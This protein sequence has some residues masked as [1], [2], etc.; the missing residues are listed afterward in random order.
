MKTFTQNPGGGF[1]AY[2]S[3]EL[4]SIEVRIEQG[5]AASGPQADFTG[6]AVNYG[7]TIDDDPN[8]D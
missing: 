6:G 7:G 1:S 8:K 2:Q 4:H 3:P 5:F